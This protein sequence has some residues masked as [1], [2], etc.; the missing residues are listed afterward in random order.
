M[1]IRIKYSHK[2]M[3]E[4]DFLNPFPARVPREAVA[5]VCAVV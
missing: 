1:F 5:V 4:L 3:M 2:K